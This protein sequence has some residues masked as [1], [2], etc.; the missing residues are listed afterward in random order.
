MIAAAEDPIGDAA[1]RKLLISACKKEV[2]AVL[3]LRGNTYLRARA[4][5][6]N[7][8]AKSHPVIMLTDQ[9][10]TED[11]PPIIRRAWFGTDRV[12]VCFN[13][14]VM[15]V[16]AWLLADQEAISKLLGVASSRIPASIEDIQNPKLFIVNLARGSRYSR[17][18]QDLVP[19]PG[20][21]AAVGPLFNPTLVGFVG[22]NWSPTRAARSAPSLARAIQRIKSKFC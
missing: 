11:C 17:I 6:L 15:E 19:S 14:A 21:T 13:V 1:I 5:E 9:D 10:R 12:D 3:Q 8:T 7:R 20:S 4:R 2:T 18:R 16:E 22:S